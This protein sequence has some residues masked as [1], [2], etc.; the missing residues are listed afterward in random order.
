MKFPQLVAAALLSALLPWT[1]GARSEPVQFTARLAPTPV[2]FRT[3][4]RITGLGALRASL[5]GQRLELT[6]KFSGL[7]GAATAARLHLGPLAIP[8]P[9]FA[10]LEVSRAPGGELN[11]TIVLTGE[12][13]QALQDRA[14]YVQI[15]S[16]AAPEGNLRGWLLPVAAN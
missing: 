4:S 15:Y 3:A 6:G 14:L 16:E 1:A 13:L 11:G 10:E 9:A 8:G 5:D 12:Q 2:D 7:Q